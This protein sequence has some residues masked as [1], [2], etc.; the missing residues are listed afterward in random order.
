MLLRYIY[1]CTWGKDGDTVGFE[2]G[3]E[4]SLIGMQFDVWLWYDYCRYNNFMFTPKDGTKGEKDDEGTSYSCN[5]MYN[6]S[7]K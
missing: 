2:R 6:D 4:D 1:P 7:G 5:M 3:S